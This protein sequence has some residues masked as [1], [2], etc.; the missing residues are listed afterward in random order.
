MAALI[1]RALHLPDTAT[2]PFTDDETSPFEASINRLAA[3]G[4]SLGRTATTYAPG[5]LVTRGQMASFLA[6]ALGLTGGAGLDL[7]PDAAPA[8]GESI[9]ALAVAGLTAGPSATTVSPP[10]RVHR[11]P[12]KRNRSVTGYY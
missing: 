2:D 3:Q 4:I 10:R 6:R 9:D 12:T 1:D 5:D 7:F 8:H 11:D